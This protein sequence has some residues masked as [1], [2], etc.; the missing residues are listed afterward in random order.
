VQFIDNA[1]IY[2]LARIT[3]PK[4][5]LLVLKLL[6]APASS[7]VTVER[8]DEGN[9]CADPIS[10][11]EVRAQVVRAM[12]DFLAAGGAPVFVEL[13]QYL[14]GDARPVEVYY[15]MTKEILRRADAF[16]A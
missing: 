13:I 7:E 4:H 5:N 1:P 9:R 2:K 15:E 8:L 6:R 11:D 10:A 3:G 12:E 16:R 14:A